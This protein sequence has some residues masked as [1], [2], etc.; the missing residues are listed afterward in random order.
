[1]GLGTAAAV[2]TVLALTVG[3][4]VRS[5]GHDTG[6]A[7]GD[8]STLELGVQA[9]V[10][11]FFGSESDFLRTRSELLTALEANRER[12]APETLATFLDSLRIIDESI[13]DIAAAH[14]A[15]PERPRLSRLLAAA[16]EQEIELLRR[17]AE[18]AEMGAGG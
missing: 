14:A 9:A 17:A 8:A 10:S 11:S 15:N 4:L 16:C 7:E 5:P 1:L 3:L 2:V 13:L 6:S 18:V 12:L